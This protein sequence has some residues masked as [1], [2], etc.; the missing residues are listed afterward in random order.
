MQYT[1]HGWHNGI[2]EVETKWNIVCL[3][4][5]TGSVVVYSV[6]QNDIQHFHAHICQVFL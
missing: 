5:E 3:R 4:T 6:D 2:F 1:F